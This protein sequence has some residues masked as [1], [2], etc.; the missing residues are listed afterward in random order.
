M[1]LPIYEYTYTM[2]HIVPHIYF[3]IESVSVKFPM[4]R[5]GFVVVVRYSLLLLSLQMLVYRIYMRKPLFGDF[6]ALA[7]REYSW[8]PQFSSIIGVNFFIHCN[9]NSY[10]FEWRYFLC[11]IMKH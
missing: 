11:L 7:D 9:R 4:F 5:F 6:I 10:I 8:D 3:P 1:M 2:T